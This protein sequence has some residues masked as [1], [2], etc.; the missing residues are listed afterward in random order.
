MAKTWPAGLYPR[1]ISF[2]LENV[3]RSGG[4]STNG[5]EQIVGSGAGRWIANY[6]AVPVTNADS[7]LAWRALKASLRGRT[8]T[9]LVPVLE[10]FRAPWPIDPYGRLRSPKNTRRARLNGTIFED[11]EIPAESAI[12]ASLSANASRRSTVVSITVVQGQKP[13]PGQYFSIGNRLH[14]I[15]EAFGANSYSIE[16]PLRATATAGTALNF[17]APVCEMRLV[18]DGQGQLDLELGRFGVVNISFVEVV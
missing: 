15:T 9:V 17:S 10:W 3:S 1:S 12:V 8:G 11:P 6:S 7:I 14:I 13:S 5:Q 16:P 2:D 18:D 4:V